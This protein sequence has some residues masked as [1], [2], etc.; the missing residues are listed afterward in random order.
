MPLTTEQIE[1]ARRWVG[2]EP[3][4]AILDDIFDRTGTLRL[5]IDEVLHDR[6]AEL[7]R[8]PASFSIPGEYSQSTA[9][10]LKALKTLMAEFAGAVVTGDVNGASN[11][12]RL[13][14]YG[15]DGL[16]GR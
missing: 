5:T 13:V 1:E 7:V 10:N 11:V 8:T 12:K 3:A 9:D 15:D 16:P 4:D 2:N 14:R 6:Y